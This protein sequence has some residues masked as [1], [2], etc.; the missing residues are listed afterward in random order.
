MADHS[1]N[2]TCRILVHP[3][4]T[5]QVVE[6]CDFSGSTSQILKQIEGA[7]PGS[8]LYI[9]TEIN[10]V[11]RAQSLRSDIIVHPLRES[12][13]NNMHKINFQN[14]L[15]TLRAIETDNPVK[16]VY[17]EKN[18]ARSAREALRRMIEYME[19]RK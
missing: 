13:C 12:K 10:F 6:A 15:N 3:E 9:G 18:I 11:R 19:K 7:A 16:E 8:I 14:L 1:R 4:C 2:H 17:V 5:P